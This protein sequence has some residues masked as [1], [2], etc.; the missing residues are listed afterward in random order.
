[1]EDYAKGASLELYF[2]RL[3]PYFY[4]KTFVEACEFCARR[5]KIVM[6]AIQLDPEIYDSRPQIFP[7]P[8]SIIQPN[9]AA[10]FLADHRL[11][12]QRAAVYCKYCHE[13]IADPA[14][15]TQCSCQA[16]FKSALKNRPGQ[17]WIPSYTAED[18]PDE[19]V[20]ILPQPIIHLNGEPVESRIW[21]YICEHPNTPVNNSREKLNVMQSPENIHLDD[22]DGD[23]PKPSVLYDS[24]GLFYWTPARPL[25]S[26]RL[27]RLQ[28]ARKNFAN[29]I[30]VCVVSQSTSQTI[31]LASFVMPLRSSAIPSGELSD[32]LILADDKYVEK[33]WKYLYNLP[34]LF[35]VKGSPLNRADLRSVN[36]NTCKMCVLIGAANPHEKSTDPTLLDK[37]V[38]LATLNVRA[39]KFSE[40]ENMKANNHSRRSNLDE[41]TETI[42]RCTRRTGFEVPLI[43]DLM[44]DTNVQFLDDD[45]EDLPGTE[46]YLTQPYSGGRAFSASVLDLLMVTSFFNPIIYTVL[47]SVIFGG[48]S[49]ELEQIMAEG[50]GLIGPSTISSHERGDQVRVKQF[51]MSDELFSM[52]VGSTYGGLFTDALLN[53]RL[54]LLGIYR[55]IGVTSNKR[56]V[57]TAPSEDFMIYESDRIFALQRTVD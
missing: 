17:Y 3:S 53:K 38:I 7:N 27:T 37:S 19:N 44:R 47:H 45:D 51:K 41:Q 25:C 5:L 10:Y 29:H 26:V 1:M 22:V 9:T 18:S 57:I 52:H 49:P 23:Q 43:T 42:K 48:A 13:D 33:E 6:L 54:L 15:I 39:M 11:D 28:A 21:S 12:V 46:F 40:D 34:R 2:R 50:A 16:G 30:V 20:A 31:G 35:V 14:Q 36:L 55:K 8:E 24:S 4:G 32:I 56:Y